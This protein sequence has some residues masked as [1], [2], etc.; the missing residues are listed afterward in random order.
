MDGTASAYCGGGG[1]PW[2]QF[3]PPIEPM[4]ARIRGW[5]AARQE[6]RIVTARVFPYIHGENEDVLNRVHQCLVTGEY[7][8]VG[9]MVRCVQ[10]YFCT[11][12]DAMLPVT[13]AKDY[14]MIQLWD[15][16]AI[17][18]VP[19][20]GRTLSEEHEAVL[21][22]L[23]GKAQGSGVEECQECGIGLTPEWRRL[24]ERQRT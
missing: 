9:D 21:S 4:M 10:A 6:V 14:Q 5:I 24:F 7:F 2:N 12:V 17:Q 11:H 23:R 18:V 13:C 22:A 20:T 16:R 3:G 15:D 19:N 8:T 1:Y